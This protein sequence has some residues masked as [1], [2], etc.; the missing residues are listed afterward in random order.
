MAF[1]PDPWFGSR[2]SFQRRSAR[3]LSGRG[4]EQPGRA[5]SPARTFVPA[6][7]ELA[8]LA[9]R[10]AAALTCSALIPAMR[11]GI[12]REA[13]SAILRP[14]ALEGLGEKSPAGP[15]SA[16]AFRHEIA[17]HPDKAGLSGQHDVECRA[18]A[19]GGVRRLHPVTGSSIIGE[20]GGERAMDSENM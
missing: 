3:L 10:M 6:P 8:A 4:R 11:Q 17:A 13:L 5:G 7:L 15:D 2:G 14:G 18:A 19:E 9:A 16:E 20:E 12:E 1:R